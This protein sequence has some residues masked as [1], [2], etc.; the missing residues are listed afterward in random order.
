MKRR[1]N[2]ACALMHNPSFVMMDEPTV[3]VDPQARERIFDMVRLLRDDGIAILYT[4]HYMEE[5]EV[6]SDRIAIMDYG[7]II[8]EG[9]LPDIVSITGEVD[10]IELEV[11]GSIEPLRA[12][13]KDAA[14]VVDVKGEHP[15]VVVCENA[16]K[17]LPRVIS[18]VTAGEL[19]VKHIAIKSSSLEDVFIKLTGRSLRE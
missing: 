1:L 10:L 4:T 16:G 17:T 11:D 18:I 5:V 19:P 12:K 14:G 8:A 9:T 13:V 3:G 15:V 6:L 2:I 7:K